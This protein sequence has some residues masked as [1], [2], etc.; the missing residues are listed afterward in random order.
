MSVHDE[1]VSR[2]NPVLKRQGYGT[3]NPNSTREEAEAAL[4]NIINEHRSFVRGVRNSANEEE[5]DNMLTSL[6]PVRRDASGGRRGFESPL[7]HRYGTPGKDYDA[8]YL[9]TNK[10][11]LNLY[12]GDKDYERAVVRI[13]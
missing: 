3:I 12:G 8:L 5:A 10:G 1:L 4:D 9:S 11:I 13:P 6:A 2:I 7:R